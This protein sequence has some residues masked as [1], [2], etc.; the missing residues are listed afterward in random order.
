MIGQRA[1]RANAPCGPLARRWTSTAARRRSARAPR[2]VCA[3]GPAP[4]SRW[5]GGRAPKPVDDTLTVGA[6]AIE[7]SLSTSR[8]NNCC[9]RRGRQT[10]ANMCEPHTSRREAA[11]IFSMRHGPDLAGGGGGGCICACW[12]LEHILG[13]YSRI[14]RRMSKPVISQVHQELSGTCSAWAGCPFCVTCSPCV[15]IRR[16]GDMDAGLE[17]WLQSQLATRRQA[18]RW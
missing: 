16:P 4:N 8:S 5:K 3:P 12:R 15:S 2:L 6:L 11:G 1:V 10:G 13:H 7:G 17:Q 14:S 9:C 18:K